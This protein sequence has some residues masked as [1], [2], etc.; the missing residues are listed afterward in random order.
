[1]KIVQRIKN[2]FR[3][4]AYALTGQTLKTLNDHPK[5]NIDPQELAR[6]ERNLRQYQG[7]YPKL[8]YV[9]SMGEKRERDYMTL[10]LRK[11]SAEVLAGLVFNEQCD[12]YIGEKEN[13]S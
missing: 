3:R 10:N 8:E 11:L 9:N 5:I 7:D 13:T 4:G 6:I 1:M 2:F 12:I